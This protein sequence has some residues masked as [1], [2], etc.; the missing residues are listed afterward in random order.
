MYAVHDVLNY[1]VIEI[2]LYIIN[3]N[4]EVVLFVLCAA[5]NNKEDMIGDNLQTHHFDAIFVAIF[6]TPTLCLKN[7]LK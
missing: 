1:C 4:Y 7:V 3:L 6:L 5:L 2:H